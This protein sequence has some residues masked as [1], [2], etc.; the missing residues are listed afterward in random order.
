MAKNDELNKNV[1]KAE[2]KS[3]DQKEEVQVVEQSES[4][5]QVVLKGKNK[6][7]VCAN[8][9]E[10]VFSYSLEFIATFDMLSDIFFLIEIWKGNQLAWFIISLFTIIGPYYICYVPLLRYQRRNMSRDPTAS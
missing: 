1:P 3:S 8:L 6:L 10:K 9:F 2:Q 7:G 5:S 4:N